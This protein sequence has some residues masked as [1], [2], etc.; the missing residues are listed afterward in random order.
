MFLAGAPRLDRV[1]QRAHESAWVLEVVIHL[2]H[3]AT[4]PIS[5]WQKRQE[6]QF[7][8][9]QKRQERQCLSLTHITDERAVD[10]LG[11]QIRL[12]DHR[13]DQPWKAGMGPNR[14]DDRRLAVHPSQVEFSCAVMAS[15]GLCVR[16]LFEFE[17]AP[18]LHNAVQ[19]RGRLL[20]A[21]ALA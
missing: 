1:V 16:A 14:R 9:S 15:C 19:G 13:T 7:S 17:R 4:A 6:R 8:L 2:Q 21:K 10:R 11:R 5:L 20:G 12:C 18:V 3:R